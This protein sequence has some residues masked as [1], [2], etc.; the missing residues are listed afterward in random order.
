MTPPMPD[1]C[2]KFIEHPEPVPGHELVVER[3]VGP[4]LPV[5]RAA[6]GLT[7]AGMP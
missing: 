6:I 1:S 5:H 7:S 2:S 3:A 4:L